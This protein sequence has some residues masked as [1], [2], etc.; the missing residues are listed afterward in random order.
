MDLVQRTEPAVARRVGL[1]LSGELRFLLLVI[2]GLIIITSIPTIYAYLT[3]PS[4][5]W[6]SGVIYNVHDTT[7]Y[8]SWMRESQERF[9]IENKLTSEPNDAIFINLHWWIPGRFAAWTGMTLPQVYQL[10]RLISIPLLVLTVYAFVAFIFRDPTRRKFSFLLTLLT[11]GLGWVWIVEKQIAGRVDVLHPTDVYTTAG[12]SFYVMMA[13]PPQ[14]FATAVTLLT[15]LLGLLAVRLHC[16]SVG[17]AAGLLALFLGM[18]HI[19]D[20]V[21]VWSVL[22]IFGILLV[23][24]DGWSWL[25]FWAL[26]I[27]VLISAPAALY[28]G[29]VSSSANPLWQQALSQY[30]N[31]GVF[32][33]DPYHLVILLGFT[34]IIAILG[35]NGIVPLKQNSINELFIKVWFGITLLLIYLPL[36]FRIML[37]TGY[38]LPM[39][40]MATWVIFD[41]IIPW[42][43]ERIEDGRFARLIPHTKLI[44]AF[45]ILAVLPTNLYLLGWRMIDLSRHN[46]PFYIHQSDYRAFQWLEVNTDPDEVVLSSF[47]I[48]HYLPGFAGNK[49]FLSN[50]VM[51][52]DFNDKYDM[53]EKFYAGDMTEEERIDFLIKYDIKYIFVGPSEARVGPYNPE[54]SHLYQLVFQNGETRIYEVIETRILST[55]ILHAFINSRY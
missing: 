6:F 40:V 18:G 7:Q 1:I 21:T 14:A 36:H 13:S 39:A 30:D 19:Y 22:A 46:Y 3:T 45:F 41:R 37:L 27:V 42:I 20:L 23:L 4:D 10:Y 50:A 52:M 44:P 29:W 9:L 43:R 2:I 28:F 11:S 54:G 47:Y 33:P 25:R 51:T 48:G 16:L 26:F 34:F 53:V 15:L 32:T 55:P 5:R 24:R 35:F 12:N 49:A 17:V 8:F 31:L 38:Q